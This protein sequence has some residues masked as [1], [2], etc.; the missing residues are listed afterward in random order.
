MDAACCAENFSSDNSGLNA[1]QPA[2]RI[3]HLKF[4]SSWGHRLVHSCLRKSKLAC[5]IAFACFPYLAFCHGVPLSGCLSC[6]IWRFC[7]CF[8][9][10]QRELG[11]CV[12]HLWLRRV[13]FGWVHASCL[14]QRQHE[15]SFS[16]FGHH[17]S[18]HVHARK[19]QWCFDHFCWQLG[20]PLHRLLE[21][22][23][24]LI[25]GSSGI[26]S[27]RRMRCWLAISSAIWSQ[28]ELGFCF[29]PD[30]VAD[31]LPLWICWLHPLMYSCWF[32]HSTSAFWQ[33]DSE[34]AAK[35]CWIE[36]MSSEYYH[37]RL[38]LTHWLLPGQRS[39]GQW[40]MRRPFGRCSC[41]VKEGCGA[42]LLMQTDN[43]VGE[44]CFARSHY[45]FVIGHLSLSSNWISYQIP[46]S[47]VSYQ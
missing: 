17:F 12:S 7:C 33:P 1:C 21:H 29:L 26:C 16:G 39:W 18:A 10:G 15:H 8:V 41:F 34:L 3:H 38:F 2:S 22:S 42:Y 24:E 28:S 13:H 19:S 46:H 37:F 27:W 6:L 30:D 25:D 47:P 9:L 14:E 45:S 31:L 35:C 32:H 40:S 5:S 43:S 23:H 20:W 4:G 36:M 44:N 11:V